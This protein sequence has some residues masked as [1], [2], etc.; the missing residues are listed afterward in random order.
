[1]V[2]AKGAVNAPHSAGPQCP[3][4]GVAVK[5]LPASGAGLSVVAK[6]RQFAC[7]LQVGAMQLGVLDTYQ[8]QPGPLTGSELTHA[9]EFALAEAMA[10]SGLRVRARP[11]DPRPRPRDRGP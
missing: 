9:L 1:V 5:T 4:C 6:D 11:A 10:R 2:Q 3:L 8:A 7:P